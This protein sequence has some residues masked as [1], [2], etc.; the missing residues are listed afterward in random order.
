MSQ[1]APRGEEERDGLA[2]GDYNVVLFS[3][4]ILCIDSKFNKMIFVVPL[5]GFRKPRH[6]AS[7]WVVWH[8]GTP[9]THLYLSFTQTT[10]FFLKNG[11]CRPAQGTNHGTAGKAAWADERERFGCFRRTKRGPT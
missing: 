7:S 3:A 6:V 10:T 1:S 2:E 11:R 5:S 4:L 8:S 9:A